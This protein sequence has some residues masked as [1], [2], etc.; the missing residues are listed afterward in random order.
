MC[1]GPAVV[2]SWFL[3]LHSSSEF[4]LSMKV[5]QKNFLFMI[6]YAVTVIYATYFISKGHGMLV[7]SVHTL[8][9]VSKNGW[10]YQ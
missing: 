1:I 2:V 5:T 8:L 3:T 6:L 10:I 9:E 7:Q 4:I